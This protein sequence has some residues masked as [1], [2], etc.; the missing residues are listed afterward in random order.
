MRIALIHALEDSVAPSRKA[1]ADNWPEAF[2]FDLLDTSLSSD[3]AHVGFLRADIYRRFEDL[4]R[5]ASGTTGKGGDTAG[6][7]FTCSAFGPAID[8]VKSMLPIPV[9]RPNESAFRTALKKGRRI[10][11]IVTFRPSAM[12]LTQELQDIA[13][14][15]GA[16]LDVKTVVVEGALEALQRGDSERHDTLAR[17]AALELSSNCDCLILGQFSLARAK[18]V[19]AKTIKHI[20]IITTPDA[21]VQ[22]LREMIATQKGQ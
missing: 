5:Y 13:S 16:Q 14:A 12:T 9:L 10:G 15:N 17:E 11:L 3:R 21:A 2:T 22:E 19:I 20:P 1:F 6:I 8:A 4:G 18:T 7:L